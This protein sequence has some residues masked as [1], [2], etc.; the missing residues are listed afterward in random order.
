M[1]FRKK[2]PDASVVAPSAHLGIDNSSS[3]PPHS[4]PSHSLSSPP[5]SSATMI[6]HSDRLIPMANN[7]VHPHGL[8]PHGFVICNR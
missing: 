5:L 8:V 3:L 6:E 1:I 2:S 4:T 7:L